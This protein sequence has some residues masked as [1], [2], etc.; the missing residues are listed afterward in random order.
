[1]SKLYLI[2]LSAFSFILFSC[3]NTSN[4]KEPKQADI[5]LIP[6]PQEYSLAEGS[7]ILNG[8]TQINNLSSLKETDLFLEQ[9]TAQIE[10]SSGIRLQKSDAEENAIL[11][12]NAKTELPKEGYKLTVDKQKVVIEASDEAGF[13]YGLQSMMQLLPPEIYAQEKQIGTEWSIP[14]ISINDYPRFSYRGLHLDVG[15]HF[16]PADSV[17]KFID[18]MA[19]Y[20]YNRFHWHLTEDQGWRIEIKKYPKLTEVGAWRKGTLVGHYSDKP[21]Q[22]DGKEYGGYYTQ[23]E[24]KEI[25][26]YAEERCI[27]IIPEIEMPGH[28]RAALAAYPELGCTDEQYEVATKWG[29]FTE[30]YCPSEKT[31]QFLQD[32][33]DEVMELF[34]GK[35]IHI[36]GDE[37]PKQQ[38]EESALCQD[39]MK[40]EGLKNEHELQSWFIQR[41]EKY[42]NSKGRSIIGWDE[43]LEGGLAPNATVMSWRGMDGGI[44]A[45]KAG[46]DVVMTPTSHCY[47]DYYQAG[48][49]G[50]PIAIGGFTPIRKV[51]DFEP[52]PDEL[53]EKQAQHILGAQ[54][55]LWTE[56][57]PDFPHVLYMTWPRA[58]ALA[59][60]NWTMPTKKSWE[61]FFP[62]LIRQMK[63]LKYEGVRCG[64]ISSRI[65]LQT[66]YDRK[67]EELTAELHCDNPLARIH[68]S[69]HGDEPTTKRAQYHQ[70]FVV[71]H[72]LLLRARAFVED[73]A[74]GQ[75]LKKEIFLHTACGSTVNYAV[76]FSTKYPA[77]G[78]SALVDGLK[79]GADFADG[80]W[81]GFNGEDMDVIINLRHPKEVGSISMQFIQK[82]A[83]WIFLPRKIEAW[84]RFE[85]TK[86]EKLGEITNTIPDSTTGTVVQEFSIAFEPQKLQSLQVIACGLRKNPP[87]HPAAGLDCW[88]FCDEII[89]R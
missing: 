20:K 67:K 26:R 28:S 9:I 80:F 29:V 14:A 53:N 27:T 54:A 30:V 58:L 60:V 44:A 83:S 61:N 22:F 69:T 2:I 36:G 88:L 79:G 8:Q 70:P 38:W 65:K 48:P 34:P 37:C 35:Y 86:M 43:I 25:V 89:I 75:E 59:E 12:Q 3:N 45:A 66:H 55:N 1:M 5:P 82:E 33:L 13:Y 50:E 47:F 21:H 81:Q 19:Q 57:M 84:G 73:E 39:I 10:K 42:L 7:F 72:D 23:E 51:Y 31:F 62:R 63:V 74:I 18:L 11:L 17:K 77:G 32:V 46:H 85:D 49:E 40:R 15:R 78:S 56:Y 68:Y 6:L 4:T 41:I 64:K 87:W 16:Y 76:P 52:V 71:Q 24:V